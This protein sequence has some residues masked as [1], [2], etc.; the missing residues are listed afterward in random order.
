MRIL[1]VIPSLALCHGG[2]S[3]VLPIIERALTN[4]GIEVETITTDDDG[5]GRRNG[6]GD[7]APRNENGIIRRYFPKQ[8][9]FYKVS[10][11]LARW[12]KQTVESFDV[13]HI[14]ALFSHTSIA[15]ARVA[16][17]A[18]V[19][20]VIRPLGVLNQYGITQRRMLLKQLS[21]RWVDGPVLRNAA[22]VHFTL[23]AEREE[24]DRLGISFHPVVIPLGLEEVPLPR[25]EPETAPYVL[26]L[27]RIDP[28]K[29][30]ECLLEAWSLV[31]LA[32][33]EWKL[34]IAGSGDAEYLAYLQKR[35]EFLGIASSI[36]WAGEVSGER[37]ARLLADA[38]IFTLPSH[39]ENFGIAAA[40]ALMAGK[41]CLFTPG[42]AIGVEAASQGAARL[43]DGQAEPFSVALADLMDHPV[44]RNAL[45]AEARRFATTELSAATMGERLERLYE[46]IT[47]TG[48]I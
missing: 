23:D 16:R 15:A 10:L 28:K 32:R 9:E 11:P 35:A 21:L 43:A 1:H 48:E 34:I 44:S 42:V 33:P 12:M 30:L 25:A 38:S 24:A 3:V 37:K 8:T 36:V 40:E 17:Q 45:A 6:N 20:Y 27:S 5:P 7:A 31:K 26:Y 22:A 18:G 13:V 14:H 29:N 4:R 46:T 19:P 41:S 47:H 2:P 39:S